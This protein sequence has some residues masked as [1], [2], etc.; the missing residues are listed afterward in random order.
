MYE[1]KAPIGLAAVKAKAGG[2]NFEICE[3]YVS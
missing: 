1:E 2:Q 3:F